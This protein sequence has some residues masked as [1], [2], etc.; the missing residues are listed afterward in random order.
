MATAEDD[1]FDTELIDFVPTEKSILNAPNGILRE[2]FSADQVFTCFNYI[3][4]EAI[5]KH[6]PMRLE[7]T[8][9]HVRRSYSSMPPQ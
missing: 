2:Y 1:H 7:F 5:D 4:D 9:L 3:L 8:A 6:G